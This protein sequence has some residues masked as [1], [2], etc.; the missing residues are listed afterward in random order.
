MDDQRTERIP[1]LT[2]AKT[3]GALMRPMV[4]EAVS[5]GRHPAVVGRQSE[6]DPLEAVSNVMYQEE[7]GAPPL[8]ITSADLSNRSDLHPIEW[9]MARNVH[10]ARSRHR[11]IGTGAHAGNCRTSTAKGLRMT[12]PAQLSTAEP[13]LGRD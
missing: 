9:R 4:S 13:F 10:A 7:P 8:D 2:A 3:T 12:V 6:V 5:R 11:L 1:R